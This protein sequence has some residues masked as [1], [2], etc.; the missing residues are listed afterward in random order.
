MLDIKNKETQVLDLVD[1][2]GD[3]GFTHLYKLCRERGGFSHQGKHC[4]NIFLGLNLSLDG[5][6]TYIY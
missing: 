3:R 1:K 4:Q 6:V 2:L 5:R